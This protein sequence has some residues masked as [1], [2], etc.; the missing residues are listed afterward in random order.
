MV[1]LSFFRSN[2]SAQYELLDQTA[3]A[4]DSDD[5]GPGRARRRSQSTHSSENSNRIIYWST[6]IIVI[7]ALVD[8]VAFLCTSSTS[9]RSSDADAGLTRWHRTVDVESLPFKNM[10]AG[11]SRLYS[12]LNAPKSIRDPISNVPKRLFRVD[13]SSPTSPRVSL[14][15]KAH[16]KIKYG[17]IWLNDQAFE[18]TPSIMTIAQFRIL[19]WG[20]DNCTLKFNAVPETG[21]TTTTTV[22]VD[23][24]K[25]LSDRMV[26]LDD[27]MLFQAP[28]TEYMGSFALPVPGSNLSIPFACHSGS[29]ETFEFSSKV[30][31]ISIE[32]D[33]VSDDAIVGPY[34]VQSQTV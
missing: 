10:Y 3:V 7:C 8:V 31:S 5:R 30:G 22:Q 4:D 27:G 34:V 23:I 17:N 32:P 2:K 29:L 12:D 28:R 6:V 20:M 13:T 18:V 15:S 25:R 16:N 14:I 11:L 9:F 21:S 24:W 26:P 33:R 19:D 1:L